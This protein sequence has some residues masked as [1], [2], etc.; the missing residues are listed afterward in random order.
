MR[1]AALFTRTIV[2]C[3]RGLVLLAALSFVMSGMASIHT[4]HALSGGHD[5]IQSVSA[6]AEVGT[7]H[8]ASQNQ[9]ASKAQ[10]DG[11]FSC[12]A[13]ACAPPLLLNQPPGF[14]L[15]APT[16]TTMLPTLQHLILSR[17]IA[18]PFRPPRSNA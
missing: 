13:F 8:C 9:P 14:A 18:L 16:G 10:K 12:C 6:Q 11:N 7:D 17:N 15:D 1:A 3:R 2:A 5:G 4:A